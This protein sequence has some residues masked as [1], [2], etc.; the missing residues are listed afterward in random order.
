MVWVSFGWTVTEIPRE[1][2]RA[3]RKGHAK[4]WRVGTGLSI[5]NC[6]ADPCSQAQGGCSRVC[7]GPSASIL[8]QKIG[9]S[10]HKP[11]AW[12]VLL[13]YPYGSGSSVLG[14]GYSHQASALSGA[15]QSYPVL[16]GWTWP[17]A[18]RGTGFQFFHF[19]F[20]RVSSEKKK[21]NKKNL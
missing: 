5:Q 4:S 10:G 13:I 18:L 12:A 3:A 7:T 17:I 11:L 2:L 8:G 14:C 1:R 21:I 20:A 19:P 6:G 15:H 16:S 9:G